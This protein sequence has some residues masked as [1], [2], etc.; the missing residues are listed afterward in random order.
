MV[1][2]VLHVLEAPPAKKTV[3]APVRITTRTEASALMRAQASTKSCGSVLPVST[4]RVPG[5]LRVSVT[6]APVCSQERKLLM[7]CL[8][9]ESAR[10]AGSRAPGSAG[11]VDRVGHRRHDG[12]RFADARFRHGGPGRTR[13]RTI[14]LAADLRRRAGGGDLLRHHGQLGLDGLELPGWTGIPASAPSSQ[15]RTCGRSASASGGSC[16]KDSLS[17]TSCPC[18]P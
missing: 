15:A 3:P 16:C 17:I 12:R 13:Q 5:E 11:P 14:G 18:R 7:V 4:L 1:E 2:H 6:T 9:R 10:R 8:G